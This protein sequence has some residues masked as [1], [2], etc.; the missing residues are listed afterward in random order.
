M[1][2]TCPHCLKIEYF[3]SM[4]RRLF[5]MWLENHD[6]CKTATWPPI[7]FISII[8]YGIWSR[9]PGVDSIGLASMEV[10]DE[11]YTSCEKKAVVF[12]HFFASLWEFQP[13]KNKS[14]IDHKGN[15]SF[16]V[17]VNYD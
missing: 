4:F 14:Y 5:Y 9:K 13:E 17:Y 7:S 1:K 11:Y 15:K 2:S 3:P 6:K 10:L 8:T 12:G 16:L